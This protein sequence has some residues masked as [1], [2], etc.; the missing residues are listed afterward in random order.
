MSF[1]GTSSA[2]NNCN[3]QSGFSLIEALVALSIMA[4]ISVMS[5]QAVDVVLNADQRSRADMSDEKQLHRAW[6]IIYRDILFVQKA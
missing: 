5:Y 1:K 3:R 2:H 4:I 6:Q